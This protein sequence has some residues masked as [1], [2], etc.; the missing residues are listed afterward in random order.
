MDGSI[1]ILVIIAIVILTVGLAIWNSK[2]PAQ[3]EANYT[4]EKVLVVKKISEVKISYPFL[5]LILLIA[6]LVVLF[7]QSKKIEDLENQIDDVEN[8]LS[9]RIDEVIM[10]IQDS[11]D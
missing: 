10:T 11:C 1:L 6:V 4:S 9:Y 5:N 8:S 3:H 7:F 2:A